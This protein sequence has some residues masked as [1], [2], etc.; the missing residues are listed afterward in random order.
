M[1]DQKH[2]KGLIGQQ[3]Y[4]PESDKKSQFFT[5]GYSILTLNKIGTNVSLTLKGNGT[6]DITKNMLDFFPDAVAFTNVYQFDGKYEIDRDRGILDIQSDNQIQKRYYTIADILYPGSDEF[7]NLTNVTPNFSHYRVFTYRDYRIN[8]EKGKYYSLNF[9]EYTKNYFDKTLAINAFVDIHALGYKGSYNDALPLLKLVDII[10][11]DTIYTYDKECLCVGF[12]AKVQQLYQGKIIIWS[13]S[14]IDSAIQDFVT[15]KT[16]TKEE[17]GTEFKCSS[18]AL[19]KETIVAVLEN[20]KGKITQQIG[21]SLYL[22]DRLKNF[23]NL[24]EFQFDQK[25]FNVESEFN[26]IKSKIASSNLPTRPKV[27]RGSTFNEDLSF[28]DYMIAY[29]KYINDINSLNNAYNKKTQAQKDLD[30]ANFEKGV[31]KEEAMHL[32]DCITKY[33]QH[34]GPLIAKRNVALGMTKEMCKTA[35]GNPG[36]TK[37]E[38]YDQN[39]VETWIYTSSFTFIS[40]YLVFVNGVVKEIGK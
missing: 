12:F 36:K 19:Y 2:A 30:W 37:I 9:D 11:G 38:N 39:L 20:E 13:P 4:Y 23:R 34:F 8:R 33:G 21:T 16:F 1:N 26:G 29:D 7:K 28:K 14:G 3:L 35:W 6:N 10:T 27:L 17:V 32:Q 15:K 40:E 31:A 18:V 25:Y 5:K 22:E 24:P